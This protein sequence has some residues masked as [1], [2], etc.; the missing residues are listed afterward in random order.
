MQVA[1]DSIFN[2]RQ[3][4]DRRDEVSD[5]AVKAKNN[6]GTKRSSCT[7][8][9]ADMD[10]AKQRLTC[11]INKRSTTVDA[12]LPRLWLASEAPSAAV[13]TDRAEA[14]VRDPSP[15]RNRFCRSKIRVTCF[16]CRD[17]R[18]KCGEK[19]PCGRCAK[20]KLLYADPPA[21]EKLT[22]L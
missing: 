10:V 15:S 5:A 16:K 11:R 6:G 3:N 4:G 12:G 21:V 7:A 20:K 13:A 8:G 22:L 2:S 18:I 14:E 19:R 9:N 1:V 17:K